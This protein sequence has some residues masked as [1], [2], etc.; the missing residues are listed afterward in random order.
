MTR[1]ES[2][3]V[4]LVYRTK[5]KGK[6]NLAKFELFKLLYLLE[7]EA[8]KFAGRSFLDSVYFVRDTNGPISVDVYNALQH[9][10]GTYLT[11]RAVKKPDYPYPRH[12]IELKKNVKD[13]HLSASEKLF[14]NSVVESYANLSIKKLKEVVYNTEPMQVI[15][16]EEKQRKVALLKGHPINF[17][18]IS[19]DSDLVDLVSS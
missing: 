5:Q 17:N 4:Y 3:I 10:N 12:C 18:V 2:I 6:H 19:L 11:L 13:F 14:I 8:R 15:Q 1:L 16:R 9:L 7:V